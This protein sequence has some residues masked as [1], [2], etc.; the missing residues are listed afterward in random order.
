MPVLLAYLQVEVHYANLPSSE[1]PTMRNRLFVGGL[2]SSVSE[3]TV[4]KS[5][6]K[7]SLSVLSQ[8][9]Q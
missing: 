2:G 9:P 4:M 6:A 3:G 5:S 7:H 8:M 1:T